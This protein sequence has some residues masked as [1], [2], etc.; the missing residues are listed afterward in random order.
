MVDLGT[1]LENLTFAFESLVTLVAAIS[2]VM[3]LYFIFRGIGMYK[4]FATQ[5]FAS[6]QKGEVAGPLVFLV[7]G[8]VLMYF[9]STLD[10]SMQTLFGYGVKDTPAAESMIGYSSISA[11]GEHWQEIS[12]VLIKYMK[13]IGFIAF[14]RGWTILSKMGHSGSQPGSVGKGI[15]HIV[16]GVLLINIVDTITL[17]AE[18]FGFTD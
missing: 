8:A 1:A 18:T 9:P 7:V 11:S 16:A 5:S 17:L 12:T 2:Y 14:L 13:L 4:I 6:A 15:V 3:G 10:T